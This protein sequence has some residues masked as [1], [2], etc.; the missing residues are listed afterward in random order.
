MFWIDL[1]QQVRDI[2][3]AFGQFS[4]SKTQVCNTLK[5]TEVQFDAQEDVLEATQS[6]D[7][8]KGDVI[9]KKSGIYLII[10]GPQIF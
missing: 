1:T 3:K 9:I 10:A 7:F 2:K 6:V 4:S 8:D 5:P